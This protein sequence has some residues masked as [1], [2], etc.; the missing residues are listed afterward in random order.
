MLKS[1]STAAGTTNTKTKQ[2][3]NQT[4]KKK[5]LHGKSKNTHQVCASNSAADKDE[6]Q[7]KLLDITKCRRVQHH[8]KR[9]VSFR[10]EGQPESPLSDDNIAVTVVGEYDNGI[11]TVDMDEAVDHGA[12]REE[13]VVKPAFSHSLDLNHSLMSE[14]L[15]QD[16]CS[17]WGSLHGISTHVEGEQVTISPNRS[18]SQTFRRQLS[19]SACISVP[20]TSAMISESWES[21]ED[22]LWNHCAF[23]PSPY[24]QVPYKPSPSP[25]GVRDAE[26]VNP[27]HSYAGSNRN[28]FP[29]QPLNSHGDLIERQAGRTAAFS[30]QN[31]IK[32]VSDWENRKMKERS[33]LSP[34]N[35]PEIPV[36]DTNVQEQTPQNE[37]DHRHHAYRLRPAGQI[38]PEKESSA[39]SDR[40]TMRLMGQ[41]FTVEKTIKQLH[42][43]ED[44]KVW[45]D[46][47]I[48][49]EQ[50]QNGACNSYFSGGVGRSSRLNMDRHLGIEE[51]QPSPMIGNYFHN[52][53]QNPSEDYFS[54]MNFHSSHGSSSTSSHRYHHHRNQNLT[55][56]PPSSATSHAFLNLD[57]GRSRAR[58][59]FPTHNLQQWLM[60]TSQNFAPS[61]HTRFYDQYHHR[62][63]NQHPRTTS[64]T[65]NLHSFSTPSY[66]PPPPPPPPPLLPIFPMAS[67]SSNIP[68]IPQFPV[69]K[70]DSVIDLENWEQEMSRITCLEE[71]D[72]I[73][74]RYD[75]TK[76][77]PDSLVIASD[78]DVVE[79]EEERMIS[80]GSELN[81][82]WAQRYDEEIDVGSSHVSTSRFGG[83]IKLSAGAKHIL[84]PCQKKMDSDNTRLT[85]STRPFAL[86]N[87]SAHPVAMKKSARIF[88]F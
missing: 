79:V 49:A 81:G 40:P 69:V 16:N 38:I 47:E 12:K 10:N 22:H 4:N 71:R 77:K 34:R 18:E 3:T 74:K 20:T 23:N 42:G 87:E 70:P 7:P 67:S 84:K 29:G 60:D 64:R 62:N 76:K 24:F 2:K 83:P 52:R 80:A 68:F 82:G 36:L 9:R 50:K 53:L 5:K 65:H 58:H 39:S 66:F 19:P 11:S 17:S 72:R 46:K 48:I 15:E 61:Y 32:P 8:V 1:C 45:T 55:G 30:L 51:S 6:Q 35:F 21:S 86:T 56:R 78:D 33:L 88:Q 28:F 85:Y 75:L 54:A 27:H 37:Y 26:S 14:S 63:Y 43:S 44:G 13:Q 41:N 57:H 31:Y 59:E 25:F 73:M